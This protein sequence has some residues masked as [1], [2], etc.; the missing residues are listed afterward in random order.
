[1]RCVRPLQLFRGM[2]GAGARAGAPIALLRFGAVS[3]SATSTACRTRSSGGEKQRVGHRAR[4]RQ[5][6]RTSSSAT[7][8]SSAL[9]VSVQAAILNPLAGLQ[10]SERTAYLFISHDMGVVR[11]LAI[12]SPSSTSEGSPRSGPGRSRRS[13]RR[14]IPTPRRSCRRVPVPI[15]MR[16]SIRSGSKVPVPIAANPPSGCPFHTR[17]P[18]KSGCS[19]LQAAGAAGCGATTTATI[20]CHI[21]LRRRLRE[22]QIK[23][24]GRRLSSK[25][26][27]PCDAISTGQRDAMLAFV[28]EAWSRSQPRHPAGKVPTR[29]AIACA[30]AGSDRRYTTERV[31]GPRLPP[32]SAMARGIRARHGCDPARL[33]DHRV[34]RAGAA[35]ACAASLVLG[36]LDSAYTAEKLFPIPPRRRAC[37]GREASPT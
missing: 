10:A 28:R 29:S 5:P 17:C 22:M 34:A 18:R 31:H 32:R 12:A 20:V 2:R 25:S 3:T 26:L 36:D 35:R 19:G 14:G 7:S 6:S 9:D 11:Y 23:E 1:M 4:I 30:A 13:R 37:A 24:R 21:P 33:G 15:P 16:R 27:P 8:R